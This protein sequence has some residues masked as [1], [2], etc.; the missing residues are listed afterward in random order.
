MEFEVKMIY[1]ADD[2]MALFRVQRWPLDGG[3]RHSF[4]K[5][6]ALVLGVLCLLLLALSILRVFMSELLYAFGKIEHKSS[7]YMPL[8]LIILGSISIYLIIRYDG[9]WFWKRMCWKN[10]NEKGMEIKFSFREGSFEVLTPAC[11]SSIDYSAI[12]QVYEEKDRF[13]LIQQNKG[14]HI[15]RKDCFIQGDPEQFR[16]FI[17]RVTQK[18][19]KYI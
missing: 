8:G 4:W 3:K 10:Y 13:L 5:K 1:D 12:A 18:P 17:S 11:A 6:A 16:D 14:A 2:L 7:H 19:T 9:D 15:L